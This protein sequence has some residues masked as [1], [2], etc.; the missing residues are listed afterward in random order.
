M[1]WLQPSFSR[2]PG[3]TLMCSKRSRNRRLRPHDRANTSRDFCTDVGSAV[4]PLAAGSPFF[5]RSIE[6]HG[7][8]WIH[9]PQRWRIPCDDGTAIMLE[10]DLNEAAIVLGQDGA[11]WRELMGPLAEQWP[12]FSSEILRPLRVFPNHPFLLARF[13]FHALRSANGLA[14]AKFRTR[15]R[16]SAVRRHRCT[17][18]PQ[19]GRAAERGIWPGAGRSGA[20]GWLARCTRRRPIAH[21][22]VVH[23]ADNSRRDGENIDARQQTF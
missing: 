23:L 8:R 18:F 21:F 12:A 3:C 13:G 9:S 16:Q 22:G 15:A 7:L 17:F 20:R 14:A 2:K 19:L 1:D 5:S 6:Q 11:A 4:Y 10:R